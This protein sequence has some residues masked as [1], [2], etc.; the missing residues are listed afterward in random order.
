MLNYF[1]K[2]NCD[3]EENTEFALLFFLMAVQSLPV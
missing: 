3:L 1:S 2:E